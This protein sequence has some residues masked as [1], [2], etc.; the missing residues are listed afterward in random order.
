LTNSDPHI[1]KIFIRFLKDI[2]LIPQERLA[3]NL[4][5]FKHQNPETLLN[6]WSEVTKIPRGRF[7]KIYIGI[8]KSS[9]SK[10]PYNSL[11]HGTIQIRVG[12]T[13]LFHKIMGWIDG[14]KKFS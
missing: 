6:F 14:M 2:C 3:A 7:D 10:K 5:I 9:L 1:I 8:S 12:D 4:R 13:K 11:P